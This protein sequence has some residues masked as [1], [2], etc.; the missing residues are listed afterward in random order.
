MRRLENV[1]LARYELPPNAL[2]R[3]LYDGL[4]LPWQLNPSNS[5]FPQSTYVRNE[6][7][8]GGILSDG[9]AFFGGSL[10]IP[11]SLLEK[12]YDTASTVTRWRDA[13]PDLANGPRDCVRMAI[14][15]VRREVGPGAG[16]MIH[17][18]TSTVLLL[19][20]RQ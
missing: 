5:V 3:T 2:S 1:D 10:D 9:V 20:K 4:G 14:E 6:W 19:F 11:I 8:R 13:N 15:Q 16:D 7:D 12:G 18:S 17:G